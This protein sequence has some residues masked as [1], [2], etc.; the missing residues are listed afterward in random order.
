MFGR[1]KQFTFYIQTTGIRRT[2]TR[3]SGIRDRKR[4]YNVCPVLAR[5]YDTAK[6][7]GVCN[8][9]E[10][11]KD[12]TISRQA[13]INSFRYDD[14]GTAW[15]MNDIVYRLEQFPPAQPDWNEMI[16]MCDCCGHAIH[17]QRIEAERLEE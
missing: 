13:I 9:Q 1:V 3:R 12:D 8:M 17:V 11:I 2:H 6:T 16:I 4:K 14:D 15:D 7:N 5:C 10:K